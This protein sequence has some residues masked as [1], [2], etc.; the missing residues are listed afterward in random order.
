MLVFDLRRVFFIIV[1]KIKFQLFN[2]I[3]CSVVIHFVI[4]KLHSLNAT[5]YNLTISEFTYEL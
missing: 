5:K 1:F 4:L 2:I 3:K